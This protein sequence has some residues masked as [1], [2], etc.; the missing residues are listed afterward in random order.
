MNTENIAAEIAD[1]HGFFADWFVG[2]IPNDAAT[3]ARCADVM[4]RG[5]HIVSPSGIKTERDELLDSL[6]QAHNSN[7][8]GELRIWTKSLTV[9]S[10]T[11][12]LALAHYEE[13][14]SGHHES[15]GRISSALLRAKPSAPHGVEWLSVHETWLPD[16]SAQ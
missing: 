3:F 14:Q 2:R 5:F 8:S 10:L 1:L 9:R 11:E 6:R 16:D 7:V 12:T 13:W 15:R 4:A